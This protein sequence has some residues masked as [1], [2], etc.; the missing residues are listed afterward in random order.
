LEKI[1][2]LRDFAKR[3]LR[4]EVGN[5]EHIHLWLDWWHPAG[6]LLQ[7]FGYRAVYDALCSK[8]AVLGFINLNVCSAAW[9]WD[10]LFTIFGSLGIE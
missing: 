3:F 2:K 7:K 8:D 4:F 1:L 6:V 9:F 5:G 10:R